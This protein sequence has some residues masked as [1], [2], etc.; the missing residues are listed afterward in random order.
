MTI[1]PAYQIL[2]AWGSLF[3]VSLGRNVIEGFLGRL[4]G[5]RPLQAVMFVVVIVV[6]IVLGGDWLLMRFGRTSPAVVRNKQEVVEIGQDGSWTRAL[7]VEASYR[8]R[9][10]SDPAATY[11]PVGSAVYDLV[12]RGQSIPV[13]C[14]PLAPTFCLLKYDSL[15]DWGERTAR[16]ALAGE[17]ALFILG[18]PILVFWLGIAEWTPERKAR[19]WISRVLFAGWALALVYSVATPT[20]AAI[21]TRSARTAARVRDVHFISSVGLLEPLLTIPLTRPYAIVQLALT[22][23]G[24][25]DTVIAVDEVDSVTAGTLTPGAAF[26]VSYLVESPRQATLDGASRTFR[27][28]NRGRN[29]LLTLGL[30]AAL[31]GPVVLLELFRSGKAG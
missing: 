10:W 13:R 22:P 26:L 4:F 6:A 21:A 12:Q 18:L 5:G 9:G 7:T 11:L 29:L 16:A 28:A 24:R 27:G 15:R 31:V 8:P 1:N 30:L 25:R 20:P 2:A 19:R 17:Q 3:A 14:L 23:A